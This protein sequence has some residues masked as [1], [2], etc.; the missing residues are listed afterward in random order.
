M[1]MVAVTN[2]RADRPKE[3]AAV[4]GTVADDRPLSDD[5][6]DAVSEV[7]ADFIDASGA[8]KAWKS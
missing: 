8:G 7:I 2:D 4:S 5:G 6:L 1:T 3:T